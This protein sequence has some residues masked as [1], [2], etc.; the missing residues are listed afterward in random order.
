VTEL[1]AGNTDQVVVTVR[2][3]TLLVFPAYLPHSVA[4]N[5]SDRER[6]S[7]SFNVMFSAFTEHFSKPL[8]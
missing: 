6:V 7:V 8:W 5:T 3:G 4:P 2:D 1:T